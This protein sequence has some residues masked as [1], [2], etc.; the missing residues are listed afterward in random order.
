MTIS[1]PVSVFSYASFHF[2]DLETPRF[3]ERATLVLRAFLFNE[4]P[5]RASTKRSGYELQLCPR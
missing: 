3:I 4:G 5:G 2:P 1:L